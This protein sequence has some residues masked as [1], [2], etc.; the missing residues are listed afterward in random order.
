MYTPKMKLTPA[1]MD[2]LN[3]KQG[4]MK[5]KIM[6]SIVR[7]GDIF[8]APNLVEVTHKEGH[9]VTSFGINLL[10]PL[11]KTMN[12]LVANDI[13]S[14]GKF[15]VDPRPLDQKNVPLGLLEKL[16]GTKFVYG[17]QKYYEEQLMKVGLKDENAFSCTCY[18]DEVGNIPK[19]GDVLSWAESSAV[20]Y[21]NSVLGA[22]CN[23]NSGMF[24]LFGSIL[25][26]VPNFGFTTD[27]GRKAKWKVIVK[28]TKIPEAQVLGS[29][30]GM[31][32]VEDVPYVMGLD[33][34]IG[35]ELNQDVKDYLKDFGAA[36][37]SNGAV[38]L[39][40]IDQIT[41][42]A[43]ELGKSLIRDDAKEYVIDDAELQRV[44]DSYPVMWK[45]PEKEADRVFVGC[46][47]LS[48]KQL[49]KWSQNIID[50]LKE[51]GQKK[52]T[53]RVVLT[54][55]PDVREKFEK[56]PIAQELMATGTRV[57]SICPLMY[58]NNPLTHKHRILTDSNKLRT[59]SSA[60]Y[61]TDQEV[62]DF[63]VGREAK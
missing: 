22:R 24:D 54:T 35:T 16:V 45:K 39:Y 15:T 7:M 55:A 60:R 2:L 51:T 20:V 48:Y 1:Q 58:T 36:T 11:Y 56:E 50:G 43:K 25:G 5:A 8:E 29:A 63:I 18:M 10:S 59:Y 32:V 28:T 46:P 3:G 62:L 12:D 9:L 17:K 26:F 44:Y 30:I 38:G 49:M 31:K 21:A 6:E 47:H 42:E 53:T 13:H 57:S 52:V 40:H 41:P 61:K 19:K 14:L 37:A 33:K 27:E 4:E 23:R 34:F